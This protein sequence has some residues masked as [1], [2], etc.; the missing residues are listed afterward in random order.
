MGSEVL[1]ASVIGND[2]SGDSIMTLLRDNGLPT[3]C[4]IRSDRITTEKKRIIDGNNQ[5][6][7]IDHEVTTLLSHALKNDL[8]SK[9]INVLS[10]VDA[11][12]F[13]DYDKGV[14]S[15]ELIRD[16]MVKCSE[17]EIPVIVDPKERN[18]FNFKGA[19]LFKPN[20][21]EF[22][23]AHKVSLNSNDAQGL[24]ATVKDCFSDIEC[25]WL[26]LTLSEKGLI[27]LNRDGHCRIDGLSINLVD[28]SG[29]GD[30]VIAL[31]TLCTIQ[32]LSIAQLGQIVNAAG[33]QV[34]EQFGVVPIDQE[35]L[36]TRLLEIPFKA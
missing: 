22:E 31:A 21:R 28:V 18:Y 23:C 10:G 20:L 19:T 14:L 24:I 33:A 15:E 34:C 35:E 27:V 7:R 26:L 5:V 8:L 30:T 6:M 25:D 9:S 12:V 17:L 2:H 11:V 4:I 1:L 3:E 32:G 36:I 29:A 16:I 13:Q